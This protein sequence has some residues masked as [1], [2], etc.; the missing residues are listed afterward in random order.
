MSINEIGLVIGIIVLVIAVFRYLFTWVQS[1]K[2]KNVEVEDTSQF[3]TLCSKHRNSVDHLVAGDK[4][5]VCSS[6]LTDSVVLLDKEIEPSSN[7]LTLLDKL[8]INHLDS[9]HWYH[10]LEQYILH[11]CQSHS[12]L[13]DKILSQFINSRNF[14][15][16]KLIIENVPKNQWRYYEVVNWIWSNVL[17]GDFES[18]LD[19]PEIQEYE[20]EGVNRAMRRHLVLNKAA[21]SIEMDKSEEN[22][23]Q[24]LSKLLQLKSHFDEGGY[25]LAL[26]YASLMPHVLSNIAQCYFLLGDL[27]MAESHIREHEKQFKKTESTESI[28]GNINESKGNLSQAKIHW[29]SSLNLQSKGFYA[30]QLRE[31]LAKYN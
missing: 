21:A 14:H 30:D 6:C 27:E 19:L 1:L 3:C 15:F 11:K 22:I 13:R 16:T 7:Q 28:L 24:N 2:K 5:A 31:K 23:K 10:E 20:D 17:L 4:G 26:N 8:I 12:L 9:D 29:Q 18:A 25:P